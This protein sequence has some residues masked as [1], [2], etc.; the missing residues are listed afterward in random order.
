MKTS[1]LLNTLLAAEKLKKQKSYS[2]KLSIKAQVLEIISSAE[3]EFKNITSSEK[4]E[5]KSKK[6]LN[7]SISTSLNIAKK[8]FTTI[9]E[10]SIVTINV[11][12]SADKEVSDIAKMN[13]E[14]RDF[15]TTRFK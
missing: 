13:V 2:T 10:N 14:T 9:E 6:N 5:M 4:V 11:E 7:N 1:Y 8:V 15:K 3:I 12:S